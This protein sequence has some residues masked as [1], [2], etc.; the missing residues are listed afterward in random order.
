MPRRWPEFPS[1]TAGSGANGPTCQRPRRF[2]A[3]RDLG[4]EAPQSPLA[5]RFGAGSSMATDGSIAGRGCPLT[6]RQGGGSPRQRPSAG[7][8]LTRRQSATRARD[9]RTL[10]RCWWLLLEISALGRAETA[11]GGSRDTRTTRLWRRR[12]TPLGSTG[13]APGCLPCFGPSWLKNGLVNFSD[14]RVHVK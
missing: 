13:A 5:A 9:G 12:L 7:A 6:P 1:P 11:S 2:R 3:A 14:C 4:G 8:V 10:V